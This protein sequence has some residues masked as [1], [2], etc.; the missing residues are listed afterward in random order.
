MQEFF[1]RMVTMKTI[2]I[3]L[4]CMLALFNCASQAQTTS[5]GRALTGGMPQFVNMA[6]NNAPKDVLVGVG[7]AR[8]GAAG[9][10]QAQTIAEARARADIS[11]Q[12]NTIVKTAFTDITASSEVSSKD[13]VSYQ[14]S[15]T[16]ALSKSTLT[17][18]TI[19][20][21]DRDGDNNY[22]VV[23]FLGKTSVAQEAARM[24]APQAQAFDALEQ[25]D[26]AFDKIARDPIGVSNN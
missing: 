19:I 6:V 25:M 9:L 15:I 16:I 3:F 1:N 14:E 20:E 21:A 17:G 7:S 13:A 24:A 22:W 5:D 26:K 23:V 2:I 11:R 12:L 8:I 18:A 10:G 4:G